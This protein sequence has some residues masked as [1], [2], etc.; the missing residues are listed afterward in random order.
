MWVKVTR[1]EPETHLRSLEG[2]QYWS[3]YSSRALRPFLSAHEKNADGHYTFSVEQQDGESCIA[4]S[5]FALILI[6]TCSMHQDPHHK[7]ASGNQDGSGI[8]TSPTTLDIIPL[9]GQEGQSS[10][11][12]N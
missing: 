12:D 10:T 8:Q 4:T 6:A 1:I 9:S 11:Q 7:C 3:S 5:V 2:A